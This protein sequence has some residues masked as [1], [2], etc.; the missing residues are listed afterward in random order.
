MITQPTRTLKEIRIDL[1]RLER[2]VSH[3]FGQALE[4]QNRELAEDIAAAATDMHHASL[5]LGVF[6]F[7]HT[8]R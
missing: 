4:N 7:P 3:H 1:M 5:K 8:T 6:A 2:E